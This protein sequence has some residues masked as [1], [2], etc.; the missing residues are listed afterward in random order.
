M[1]HMNIIRW[2]NKY[3]MIVRSFSF[4]IAAL[5]D[6]RGCWWGGRYKNDKDIELSRVLSENVKW[7]KNTTRNRCLAIA[8]SA[9][10]VKLVSNSKHVCWNDKRYLFKMRSV[11][12]FLLMKIAFVTMASHRFYLKMKTTNGTDECNIF[13]S[14][15]VICVAHHR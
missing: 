12:Q 14:I 15:F 6:Q 2:K 1:Q 13:M 7:N 9:S 4:L 11:H 8:F 5:E 10:L 3:Y